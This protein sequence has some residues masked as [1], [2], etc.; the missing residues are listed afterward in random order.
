MFSE[1]EAYERFMGTWRRKLAPSF[2]E[3]A[4][5]EDG[6]SVLDIGSRTGALAEV[7]LLETISSRVPGVDPPNAY[8]LNAQ[9]FVVGSLQQ[10]VILAFFKKHSNQ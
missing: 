7:V 10:L 4:G 2:L 3:F 1:S 9:R 5:L 6:D 8:V